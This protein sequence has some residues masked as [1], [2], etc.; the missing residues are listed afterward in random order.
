MDDRAPA[1]KPPPIE[2]ERL[3]EEVKKNIAKAH[4]E[5]GTPTVAWSVDPWMGSR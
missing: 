1:P 2:N 5:A 3:W 4:A